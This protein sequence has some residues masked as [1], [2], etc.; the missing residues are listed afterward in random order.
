MGCGS[1][2]APCIWFRGFR[3]QGDGTLF[4]C[5]YAYRKNTSPEF[6][7][8]TEDIPIKVTVELPTALHSDLVTYGEAL[9]KESAQS[10]ADPKRL[11]EPMLERF[12]ATDR[13]FAKL[14]LIG[15]ATH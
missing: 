9:A 3:S 1:R 2:Q 13:G 14:R 10:A 12:V 4:A 15:S 11:I 8:I 7:P 6:S 5:N